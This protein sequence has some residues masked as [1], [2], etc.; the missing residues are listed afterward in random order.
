MTMMCAI[1]YVLF[2]GIWFLHHFLSCQSYYYAKVNSWLS[3]CENYETSALQEIC[4]GQAG[5][6]RTAGSAFIFFLLATIAVLLKPSANREAWLAKYTL[7]LFL[8]TGT[9]FIP[10]DPF[11]NPILMNFFRAGGVL[12][13]LFQQ[14]ILI[15]FCYNLNDG[16]VEKANQ[17]ELDEGQGAGNKWLGTLISL[18]IICF[19]AAVTGIVL[20][21][22]YFGDC[23]INVAFITVTLVLGVISIFM[24]LM[25]EESSL[26][27]STAIFTYST[28]L[29]YS[30]VSKNPIQECNPQL[31]KEDVGGIILGIALALISLAWTGF[32]Y[33]AGKAVGDER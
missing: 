11:F 7:F 12:F 19:S 16:M 9:V 14:I 18:C 21:Y 4:S 22:L 6:Y 31:G 26:L 24:Q 13:I 2:H 29:C 15:D 30:A 1:V 27:T 23:N 25:G 5:V 10:N 28:Y 17:A 33:T 20:M 3:G 8:V 32:S